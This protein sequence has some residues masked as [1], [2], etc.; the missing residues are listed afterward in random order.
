[1]MIVD[2]DYDDFVDDYDDFFVVDG[3]DDLSS[4]EEQIMNLMNRKLLA[5]IYN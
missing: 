1:M 5:A 2:D 4:T 3:G